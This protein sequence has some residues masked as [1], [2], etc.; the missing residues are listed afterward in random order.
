MASEI[1]DLAIGATALDGT[2]VQVY[3]IHRNDPYIRVTDSRVPGRGCFL[4]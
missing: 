1:F 3:W 2:A 4:W